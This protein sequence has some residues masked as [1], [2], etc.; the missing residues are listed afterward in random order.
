[1]I[2]LTSFI[3]KANRGRVEKVLQIFFSKTFHALETK[4]PITQLILLP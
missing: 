1:M 4:N 2:Q 3:I